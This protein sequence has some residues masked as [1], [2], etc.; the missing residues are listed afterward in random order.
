[1]HDVQEPFDREEERG[2]GEGTESLR[3]KL[4]A[5][6]PDLVR[7]AVLSGVGAVLSSEEGIRKIAQDFSLPKD[8]ANY[9]IAQANSTKDEILRI[10]GNEVRRFLDNLNL[11]QELKHLL[12][13][14]SFEIKT[15]IRFIPNESS[16]KTSHTV[17]IKR[18]RQPGEAVE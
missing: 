5:L 9:I 18:A 10:I 12:T 11:E 2:E 17:K 6:V 3:Q 14:L 4:E 1:M 13:S 15:E 8:V 16:P 7:R